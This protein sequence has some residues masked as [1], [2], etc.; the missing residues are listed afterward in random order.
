MFREKVKPDAPK[1]HPSAEIAS[2][3]T[4]RHSKSKMMSVN[5]VSGFRLKVFRA[6]QFLAPEGSSLDAVFNSYD[7]W[8]RFRAQFSKPTAP[9]SSSATQSPEQNSSSPNSRSSDVERG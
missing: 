2:I 3:S 4:E 6:L 9:A 7:D 8:R 5:P 1:K